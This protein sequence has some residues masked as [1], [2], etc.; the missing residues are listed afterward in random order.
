MLGVV[1]AFLAAVAVHGG[2]L[3]FGG[4]F[5]PHAKEDAGTLQEVELVG[6]DVQDDKKRE[7]EKKPQDQEQK[8]EIAADE[9]KPPDVDEIVRNLEVATP[10][11]APALE[12]ASLAAI[13]QA[14]S[15]TPGSGLFSEALSFSSG[16][17]IGGAGRASSL[18]EKLEN[19]FS[20][21]EIDQKPRPI[22]QAQPVIPSEM[23]GKKTEGVVTVTFVVDTGGKATHLKVEKSSHPAFEKPALDALKQWKFEPAIRGGQR[24]NCK[25]RLSL[26][27]PAS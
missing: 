15:G 26:R 11:D 13:E 1:L 3:L 8:E 27:F 9:E 25:S 18:D 23:R 21:G 5:L 20:M 14:L 6:D 10:D 4:I 17:R 19:A 16:G 12:A 24:V 22:F 7:E 2:M